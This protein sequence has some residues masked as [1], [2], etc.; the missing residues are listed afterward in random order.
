[1]ATPN[2]STTPRV[3]ALDDEKNALLTIKNL[4][5]SYSY[6]VI[7]TEI[8]DEALYLAKN[9]YFDAVIIDQLLPGKTG[10]EVLRELRKFCKPQVAII[11]SGTE[12]SDE[13]KREMAEIGAIFIRKSHLNFMMEKLRIL[14]EQEHS[15]IKIFI[16]YT[17]PDF[18]KVT[19]I[20]RL[21]KG[22]GFVPWIDKFDIR[23]GYTWNREIENAINECDF[24]LSCLSDI[25]LKRLGYFQTETKLAVIKH[26]IVGEPFIL[27]L[28]FDNCQMPPE[29]I[30]R[31]LQYINYDPLHDDWWTK[32]LRTLRSKK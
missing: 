30:E 24:F 17:N 15:P 18:D 5:E 19:W 16:S 1:M 23:P 26:D 22:D 27:P 10:L 29:F 13:V 7:S 12:P 14:L 6:K 20:Y 28:I 2:L 21:L 11:I 9:F 4:L 25:A 31:N 3:L 8:P 32:L